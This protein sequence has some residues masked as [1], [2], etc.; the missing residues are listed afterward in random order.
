MSWLSL[1]IGRPWRED[2][3]GLDAYDCKGLV[4]AVQRSVW[5]REVPAL[6]HAGKL[7]DWAAVRAAC[8]SEGWRPVDAPP[9]EGD[10]LVVH[11]PRGPHVGTF[12]RHG[13]LLQVLHAFGR[14]DESG[15][16]VGSVRINTLAEMLT[17]GYSR[18][19]VWRWQGTAA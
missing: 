16:Q 14:R 8:A 1:Y 2:A 6:L 5:D 17:G 3:E 11:G 18:P 19:Q 13:R 15:R 12:V 9:E 10:I 7:T 4:R